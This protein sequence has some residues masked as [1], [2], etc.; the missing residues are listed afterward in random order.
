VKCGDCVE[1]CPVSV[2][3]KKGPLDVPKVARES[4]FIKW[5]L[6]LFNDFKKKLQQ[7]RQN[8][9]YSSKCDK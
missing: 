8:A 3:E 9:T 4:F 5:K 1:V 7:T 6:P 2:F